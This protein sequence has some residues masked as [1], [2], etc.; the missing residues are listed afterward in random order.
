[1]SN[2]AVKQAC[3]NEDSSMDCHDFDKSKSRNDRVG[4]LFQKWILGFEVD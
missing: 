2:A 1:M 4:A 3:E